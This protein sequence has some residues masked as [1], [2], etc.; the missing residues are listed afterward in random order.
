[1]TLFPNIK[2]LIT[3]FPSFTRVQKN[4]DRC[5]YFSEFNECYEDEEAIL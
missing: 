4:Q 2:I 1:M 5:P 3:D